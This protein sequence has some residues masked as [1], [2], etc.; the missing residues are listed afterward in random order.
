MG[1]KIGSSPIDTRLSKMEAAIEHITFLT[2]TG[3]ITINQLME[4][5]ADGV[6]IAKVASMEEPTWTTAI[7]KNVHH[8]VNR[9]VKTLAD[10]PKQEERKLNLRFMGFE[11]KEG[12][13]EKELV[14]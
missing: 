9:A 10:A 2:A 7:A 6:I 4:H 12:E 1:F 5:E 11:A 8:M 3:N 14:Q 13:I